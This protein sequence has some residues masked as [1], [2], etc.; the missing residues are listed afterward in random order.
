MGIIKRNNGK[1]Y[2]KMN[3][4]DWKV[5]C[6]LKTDDYETARKRADSIVDIYFQKKFQN[7]FSGAAF[8]P[9]YSE[10]AFVSTP[11]KPRTKFSDAFKKYI[12]I[13]ENSMLAKSTM[14]H[15]HKFAKIL[16]EIQIVYLDELNSDFALK[17][18]KYLE[19]NYT[20]SD[21]RKKYITE[22]SV[23]LNYCIKQDLYTESQKN[24]LEF[25]KLRTKAREVIIS[26]VDLQKILHHVKENWQDED[27]YFYLL[28]LYNCF[29]RPSEIVHLEVRHFDF[30]KETVEYVQNKT[31]KS[32]TVYL[33]NEYLELLKEFIRRRGITGYLF[34]GHSRNQ[35]FYSKKFKHLK[36]ELG[37]NPDY[38]LYTYRH[39]S[40]TNLYEK[41]QDVLFCANMI[42]DSP[43]TTS[44]HYL[45]LKSAYYKD[46]MRSL[47][48]RVADGAQQI[49]MEMETFSS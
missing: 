20:C 46:K 40:A 7:T 12:Q 42:G 34:E 4:K 41:T 18:W 22:L 43:E 39:T 29:G 11:V 24:K 1:Y 10:P 25:P 5:N 49:N 17:Y 13:K 28:T 23:F 30:T 16:E 35:E 32:K 6:S 3:T 21:S 19:S 37:L 33:Q 27:F 26:E 14:H 36:L 44:K 45:N 47:K 31:K 48:P 2:F 15:K 9:Y 38:T 8:Q